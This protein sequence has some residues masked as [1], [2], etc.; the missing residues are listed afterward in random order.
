MRRTLKRQARRTHLDRARPVR[1]ILVKQ[2]PLKTIENPDQTLRKHNRRRQGPVPSRHPLQPLRTG[3]RPVQALSWAMAA[4]SAICLAGYA[5][6]RPPPDGLPHPSRDET[7]CPHAR[8]TR[9]A[10]DKQE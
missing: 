3:S 7:R 6:T 9:P 8:P 5:R 4:A 10:I 1:E 2:S